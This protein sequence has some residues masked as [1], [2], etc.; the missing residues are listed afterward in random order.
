[1]ILDVSELV[2]MAEAA[3]RALVAAVKKKDKSDIAQAYRR[4][5]ESRISPEGMQIVARG[6]YSDA[7]VTLVVDNMIISD[8]YALN[9][10]GFIIR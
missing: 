6:G 4:V 7:F 9:S 2:Q 3:V 10:S 8:S 1:L 5:R